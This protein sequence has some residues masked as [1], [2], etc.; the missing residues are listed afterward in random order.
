VQR[1]LTGKSAA[2]PQSNAVPVCT[3]D[4][5]AYEE[6]PFV[7]TDYRTLHSSP[8]RS[9]ESDFGPYIAGAF[10]LPDWLAARWQRRHGGD[11]LL[12][13]AAW[14]ATPGGVS[15][16]VN[17]LRATCSDVLDQLRAAGVAAVAGGRE[18]AIRLLERARI[19]QLPGFSDGLFS[20]QDESSQAA[21]ALVDPQPGERV[22][23]LCAAPGGKS[24]ALAER[25]QNRGA[26]IAAD[27]DPARVALIGRGARRL[28]LTI[29]EPIVVQ[30]DNSNVPAGPFDRI[31]LDVPCSN[32]GVLGKRAEAR[33]RI[34]EPGIVE[35]AAS[36]SALL[37][38]AL[39]RL[40]VGGLLVYS[41][42]SIEP[43]DNEQII[44][45]VLS[46]HSQLK[47][48]RELHHT[49]GRPGDGGYQALVQRLT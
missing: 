32:T 49:P 35:L 7:S 45:R 44:R 13:L 29:I 30:A 15:L 1:D 42:C 8:F 46:Q 26:I 40:A 34:S 20:V 9:P 43:E 2:G 25:M 11:E 39:D 23:D 31:L 4:T 16:R 48:L 47:L 14:F 17:R 36:Q 33:W 28:G 6:R 38:G 18:D 27:T 3:I 22:L 5:T 21:A 24:A 19:E 12:R 10:S 37:E 41:T